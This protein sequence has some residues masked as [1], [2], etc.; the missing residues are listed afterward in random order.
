VLVTARR[1]LFELAMVSRGNYLVT[2]GALL[3][4]ISM[5]LVESLAISPASGMV[6]Y[7]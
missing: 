7:F 2:I 6:S 1:D 4:P 5:Q 3:T